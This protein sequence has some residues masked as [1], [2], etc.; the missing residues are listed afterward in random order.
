MSDASPT[1]DT[2]EITVDGKPVAARPGELVIA[3][4]ERNGVYIPHFCY[5]PRMN[6]VGMCRMCLVDI[7]TGRGPMLQ[8]SCMVP[9]A[10]NMK[11]ETGTP[12]VKRAQEGILELLLVNHPLDCPVCDKGGECP[13]QDQTMAYGPGESRFVE[14]KRHYEKPIPVNDLVFLDRERCILCDRCTRFAKEVAGDPLIH[15]THRGNTTQVLT[16]PD[17][18]F[19][20]YF[21]GN[22]V[23][24]CPVGALTAKPYRFKAR[25]WDLEQLESTCTSCSVG[26]RITVQSS[27][28]QLLRYVGSDIDSVNW[29]WL[30]DKGRFGFESVNADS[31][32]GEPLLRKGDDLVPASW[33]Q[34]LDAAA[35]AVKQAIDRHGAAGVALI[36]GARGTNEDAYAWAKFMREAVGSVH[37]DAQLGDGLPAELV[38]GLPRATIN[39][40]VS[41]KTLIVLAPDL[42]EELPV[43]Y[44]RVRD[45][46]AKQRTRVIEVA[47]A[48]TGL[49]RE[50]W[51]SVRYR[52][53]EQAKAVRDLL[54]EPE[55][56]AQIA[57]GSV[58]IIVGRPSVAESESFTVDAIAE[59]HKA[60]PGATF[61][62]VLRRGNVRGAIESGL[63][64]GIGGLGT[65]EI[66][67]GAAQGRIGC[68]IL[69]GADPISDF[70]DRALVDRALAAVGSVVAVDTHLSPSAA[71]AS[72]V[73]AA[74]GFAEKSGTVTNV[75]GRVGASTQKVTP[76][77][78]ARADWIVAAELAWRLD[79]DLGIESS[80]AI[81][82]DMTATLPNFAGLRVTREGELTKPTFPAFNAPAAT[83]EPRVDGYAYRLVAGR[84]LY[85][86]GVTVAT[87]ASLA[88][89]APGASIALNATEFSR[90]GIS[91]GSPVRVSSTRT[92]VVLPV[93]GDE[94]VPKGIARVVLNQPNVAVSELID[95]SLP[96][97]DV[98]VDPL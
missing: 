90:L 11:V 39:S 49:T 91:D 48:E 38:L 73:L 19:A 43:L 56:A 30:C 44:L 94:G 95:V 89:L 92:S 87:S 82:N 12:A 9:V 51:R 63:R 28:N 98:K 76:V 24:I 36:G 65:R 20:S 27:R 34:A 86:A 22:T 17:E 83:A 84:K 8:P 72:V 46:V 18:P 50:A 64:P 33:S 74:A 57:S 75:E 21:S 96:V 26:C 66:L 13:L 53:G 71:K 69:L 70:P 14:E 40:A 77:G 67:E 25:P 6:P 78:T 47:A 52:P 68:L 7:D 3:A 81:W 88:H 2:I 23:Q 5:H 32:L 79:A 54:A 42:K 41:A 80:E 29:G 1:N 97:T 31:R 35:S 85:D 58:A 15:F 16:F 10:P 62:P 59:L 4:A 60:L 93:H 61:L 55:L 45:A 37:M